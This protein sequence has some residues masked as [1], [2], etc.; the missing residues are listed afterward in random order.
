MAYFSETTRT[1]PLSLSERFNALVEDLKQR[2]ERR[3]VYSQTL[4][5]LMR[6]NEREL[7]DLGLTRFMLKDVARDAASRV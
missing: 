5:E 2:R 3:R 4:T 1:A 6:M 7:E